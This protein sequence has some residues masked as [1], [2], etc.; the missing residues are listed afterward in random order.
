MT[1]LED[2]RPNLTPSVRDCIALQGRRA[3][4][5]LSVTSTILLPWEGGIRN[6]S[7]QHRKGLIWDRPRLIRE[8]EETIV[9]VSLIHVL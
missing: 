2:T 8:V 1:S 7:T 4:T 3:E 5:A 9:P 6:E